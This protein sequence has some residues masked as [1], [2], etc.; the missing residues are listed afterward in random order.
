MS[1]WVVL[2]TSGLAAGVAERLAADGPTT[3][4]AEAP[5]EGPFRWR[6]GSLATGE[7]LPA[8]LR[9]DNRL[10]L[11]L[12]EPTPIAGLLTVLRPGMVARGVVVL[13]HDDPAPD[14]LTR[15]EGSSQLRVGP[16]WG[17]TEPLIAAWARQI[18]ASRRILVADPGP[19]FPLSLPDVAAA[20]RAAIERPGR[21]WTLAGPREVRLPQLAASLAAGLG[22]PLRSLSAP[23]GLVGW[24]AGTPGGR[25][26]R[27]VQEAP[28]SADTAGW[29]PPPSA[30]EPGWLGE[31]AR[32]RD[33]PTR[34]VPGSS[35]NG[36]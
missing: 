21:R 18:A 2:G 32:W 9:A 27:W 15:L 24:R 30:G 33:V 34:P 25:L 35:P 28:T 3:L 7:G 6:R 16:V 5:A 17:P 22:L 14:L 13:A 20:V 31:P 26:R 23:L 36:A 10:V 19:V 29:T 4:V 11:V 12:D 1:A 8:V